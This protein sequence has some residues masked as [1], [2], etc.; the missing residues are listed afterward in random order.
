MFHACGTLIALLVVR[1]SNMC[2]GLQDELCLLLKV[3]E[4]G[5]SEV[6]EVFKL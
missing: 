1:V 2:R 4:L 3:L 5:S 6:L